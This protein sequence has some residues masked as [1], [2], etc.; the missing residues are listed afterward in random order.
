MG[1]DKLLQILQFVIDAPGSSYKN[2]LPG[3]LELCLKNVYPVIVMQAN[4]YPDIYIALLTLLHRFGMAA[5]FISF[6]IIFL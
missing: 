4:E 2:F 1:L 5:N 3:I 6:L